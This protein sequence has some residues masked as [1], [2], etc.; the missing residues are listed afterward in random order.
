[1]SETANDD[2]AIISLS[3]AIDDYINSHYDSESDDTPY[4]PESEYDDDELD[5]SG[6]EEKSIE[7]GTVG[8]LF[9][10]PLSILNPTSCFNDFIPNTS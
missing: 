6:D 8:Q 9:N 10:T 5:I 1:M 4:E 3:S 7:V 2:R